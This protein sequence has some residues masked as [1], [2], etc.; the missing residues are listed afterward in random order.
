MLSLVLRFILIFNRLKIVLDIVW[1]SAVHHEDGLQDI[2]AVTLVS[3][4][5]CATGGALTHAKSSS[6]RRI[7]VKENSTDREIPYESYDSGFTS[8][9]LS[10]NSTNQTGYHIS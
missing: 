6:S 10:S 5:C 7:R 1:V 2:S 8:P 3:L 9:R 4:Y